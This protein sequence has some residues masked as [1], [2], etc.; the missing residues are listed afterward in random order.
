MFLAGLC[1]VAGTIIG[2]RTSNDRDD[3]LRALKSNIPDAD[4]RA[5]IQAV[6]DRRGAHQDVFLTEVEG[7]RDRLQNAISSVEANPE[8][9]G[10]IPAE[11]NAAFLKMRDEV[12]GGSLELRTLM[13]AEEWA[14]LSD[15]DATTIVSRSVTLQP[16]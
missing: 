15:L 5:K 11:F 10:A 4:R 14:T 7:L 3:F 9:S 6:F 12:I 2:C 16:R 13:S 1:V 8:E